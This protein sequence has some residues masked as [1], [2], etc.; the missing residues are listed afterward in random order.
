M[1]IHLL[2]EHTINQIAAG[3]VIENTASVVK[4][5]IENSIDAQATSISIEIISGGRQLIRITDDGVGMSFEDCRLSIERYATSKIRKVEDLLH[6]QTMGFRGEALSSIAAIS[7]MKIFTKRKNETLGTLLSIS[8]GVIDTHIQAQMHN[9]TKIE[10]ESLFFNAPARRKFQKS[11]ERDIADVVKVALTSSLAH[12]KISFQLIS[13]QKLVFKSSSG[14]LLNRIKDVLGKEFIDEMIPASFQSDLVQIEGFLS[15]PSM[16]RPNRSGQYLFINDRPVSCQSLSF[17]VSDGYATLLEPRRYPLFV[18]HFHIPQEFIDVNVHPQKK[19]VRLRRETQI[20]TLVTSSIE[21]A[22]SKTHII[23]QSI[24]PLP[25]EE[26]SVPNASFSFNVAPAFMSESPPL[27][28]LTIY[29]RLVGLWSSYIL[30]EAPDEEALFFVD[31]RALCNRIYFE[32]Y[33]AKESSL[34]KQQ[35]TLLIPLSFTFN[36]K[37]SAQLSMHLKTLNELGLAIRAFGPNTFVVEAIPPAFEER[38]IETLLYEILGSE[39]EKD[40]A[41]AFAGS[42]AVSLKAPTFHE[43]EKLIEKWAK[44]GYPLYCPKGNQI[45]W[46]VTKHSLLKM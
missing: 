22:L 8:G 27:P 38:V 45:R 4:E 35:Q 18:L 43:A 5:L 39:D 14:L 42:Q 26:K 25:W 31:Q 36:P 19:E 7:K 10:V 41:K 12:P 3:E 6:L 16:T 46:L 44:I 1:S 24:K 23:T 21:K 30:V 2:D 17:A 9:G 13:N 37:E 20:R 32:E 28:N 11:I 40:I 34:V 29:P 33:L 15:M